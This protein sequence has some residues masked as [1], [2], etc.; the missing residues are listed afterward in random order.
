MAAVNEADLREEKETMRNIIDRAK[1]NHSYISKSLLLLAGELELLTK[2]ML[3]H[4]IEEDLANVSS[5]DQD[6]LKRVNL[7]YSV[8]TAFSEEVPDSVTYH[9]DINDKKSPGAL[10]F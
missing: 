5:I 6:S 1:I 7:D 3:S 10:S 2:N 8:E 4:L 9:I